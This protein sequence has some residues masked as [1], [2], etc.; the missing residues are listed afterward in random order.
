[1]PAK[2][3]PAGSKTATKFYDAVLAQQEFWSATMEDEGTMEFELPDHNET[4]G[5]LLRQQAL[6]SIV[7]DMI[8]RTGGSGNNGT[9]LFP[10]D[11]VTGTSS[12]KHFS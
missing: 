8:T 7:R 6:H 12:A 5:E 4:D 1:M 2:G 10:K 9:G 11:G 3:Q